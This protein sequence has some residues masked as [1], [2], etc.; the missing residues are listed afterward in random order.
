MP[1]RFDLTGKMFGSRAVLK[2]VDIPGRQAHWLVRCSCGR[3]DV[4]PSQRLRNGLG[5]SCR[6]CG[7]RGNRLIDISGRSFGSWTALHW[8]PD[9]DGWA[10]RCSC[11]NLS[12]V[13]GCDL[14]GGHSTQ[15]KVCSSRKYD[16][17]MDLT[18][19]DWCWL[20]GLFHGDT[21]DTE[22][23]MGGLWTLP[24]SPKTA[25]PRSSRV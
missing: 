17:K 5:K 7:S 23:G 25:R 10:V 12:T 18:N 21:P 3:E 6:D 4:V 19:P 9:K 13:K 20:L 14:R 24:A 1:K 8:N 15:C 2:K 16:Y 11:G 22:W